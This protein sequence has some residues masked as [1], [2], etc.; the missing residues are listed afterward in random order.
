MSAFTDLEA[1][2]HA[3]IAHLE[4]KQ[5][6]LAVE[7]RTWFNEL[8]GRLPKVEAE[9]KADAERVVHDAETAAVP[10]VAE[11]EHDAV[12]IAE[13]VVAAEVKTP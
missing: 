7:F 4:E 3:L 2:G 1:R 11:A 12:K 6:E 5:H 13:G 9:V 10:V 8:T